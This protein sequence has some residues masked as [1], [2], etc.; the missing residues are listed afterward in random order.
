MV[1]KK[2]LTIRPKIEWLFGEVF[3]FDRGSKTSLKFLMLGIKSKSL[4]NLKFLTKK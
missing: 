4:M 2:K 3:L 1:K